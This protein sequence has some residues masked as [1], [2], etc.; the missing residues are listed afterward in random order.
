VIW[1]APAAA[2]FLALG[3][4]ACQ[5]AT[6]TAQPAGTT[7]TVGGTTIITSGRVRVETGYVQ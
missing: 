2:L 6:P 4:A 1:I 5:S 7:T 3:L